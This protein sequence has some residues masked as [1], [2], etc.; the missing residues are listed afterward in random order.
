MRKIRTERLTHTGDESLTML[1][2]RKARETRR[3][4]R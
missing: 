1:Q 4:C 3:R 2:R